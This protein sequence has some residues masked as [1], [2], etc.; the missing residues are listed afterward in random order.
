MDMNGL[1][2]NSTLEPTARLRQLSDE[3]SRIAT[4]LAQLVVEP[5]LSP[6]ATLGQ[7]ANDR[8]DAEVAIETVH[9]VIEARRLRGQ[10]FDDKL[11]ADPAWDML[12]DLYEAEL[13][14]RRVTVTS[15]CAAAAVPATTAVRWIT[16]MTDAGLFT[17]RADS[18]DGRRVFVEL[19]PAASEGMRRYFSQL[20]MELPV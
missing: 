14:Q 17:R 8:A 2:G 12:L 11:F 16:V 15:L 20:G 6:S 7:P 1:P 13:A 18:L 4:T 3:V 9:S 10:F 5:E 19:T